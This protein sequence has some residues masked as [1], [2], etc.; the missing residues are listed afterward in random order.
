[1]E[2]QSPAGPIS[3]LFAI[4][5][6]YV[7]VRE[8]YNEMIPSAHADESGAV[9]VVIIP[10]A[11]AYVTFLVVGHTVDFCWKSYQKIFKKK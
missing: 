5:V 10:I 7:T 4:P 1:M 8:L 3:A 9:G 2:A 6:Y 11:A